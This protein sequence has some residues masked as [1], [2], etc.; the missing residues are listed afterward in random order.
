M[1]SPDIGLM[2]PAADYLCTTVSKA[3][4]NQDGH[5]LPVVINCTYIKG[6]DYTI[7]MVISEDL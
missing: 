5:F 7:A 6:V 4:M 2:Y 3:G 1:V